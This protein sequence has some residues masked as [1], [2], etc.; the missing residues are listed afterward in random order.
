MKE[1]VRHL[2]SLT[3]NR[4][5]SGGFRSY[6]RLS[7]KNYMAGGGDGMIRIALSC[8]LDGIS[9]ERPQESGRCRVNNAYIHSVLRA[10]A[11][12][13]PVPVMEDTGSLT[14]I[15]D[16]C[17]GLILTGGNDIAP[18]RYGEEQQPEVRSVSVLR[19]IYESLLFQLALERKLPVFGICRGMQLINVALGGSLHQHLGSVP[20][21]TL[22]HDQEEGRQ[23]TTHRVA[24]T[25]GSIIRQVLGSQTEVN[26]FHHQA[27][28]SLAPGLRVTA[29]SRDGVIE[30]V[31]SIPNALSTILGVQWHPE[32]LSESEPKTAA[33]FTLF[34]KMC[35]AA[36]QA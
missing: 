33:L 9:E 32:E 22:Q 5:I 17:D 19:D 13:V 30:A 6:G 27:I 21:F 11:A 20:T 24:V 7:V 3:E 12:P 36:T 2:C 35:Q 15:L 28:K 29:T 10:G 34:V 1:I 18:S 4:R 16:C 31:E 26:S 25:S 14:S 23:T 8:S